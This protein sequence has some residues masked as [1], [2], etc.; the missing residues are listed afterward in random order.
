M[1]VYSD[2]EDPQLLAVVGLMEKPGNVAE[3]QYVYD[4][5]RELRDELK[6]AVPAYFAADTNRHTVLLVRQFAQV[7]ASGQTLGSVLHNW[8]FGT[9]GPVIAVAP[10]PGTVQ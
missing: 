4:Y 10:P 9:G 3:R 7:T 8:Y 2:E 6:A 1:F 5:A